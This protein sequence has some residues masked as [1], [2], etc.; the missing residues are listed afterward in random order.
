MTSLSIYLIN[1]ITLDSQI[2]FS[3]YFY[4]WQKSRRRASSSHYLL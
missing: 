2:L 3:F 1:P 4:P